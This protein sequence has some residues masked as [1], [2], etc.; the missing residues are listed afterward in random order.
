MGVVIIEQGDMWD[1]DGNFPT[2]AAD[3][4]TS[5]IYQYKPVIDKIAANTL[6]FG[7][8]VLLMNGDSHVYR[9]DSPLVQGAP[10]WIE[11]SA[12][13]PAVPCTT[14]TVPSTYGNKQSDPWLNQPW[15]YNVPNLR[16]ITW[17]GQTTKLEYVRLTVDPYASNANA[18]DSFGPFSWTRV[19]P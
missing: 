5:H 8:P 18:I 15:G 19:A 1:F 7:K 11:P 6:S 2:N 14:T 9:T 16:R 10:C 12:N 4:T 13:A 3:L 17:H